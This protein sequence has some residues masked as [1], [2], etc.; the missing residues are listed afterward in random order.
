MCTVSY[1]PT[2][3][4]ALLVSNRD[5]RKH[6]S[7]AHPPA[8]SQ[9]NGQSF[10]FPT[11]GDAG[12][13]WIMAGAHRVGVLLNGAFEAHD[14]QPPYRMSRG[15]VL[16]ELLSAPD[17]VKAWSLYHLQQ[18]EPFTWILYWE[19]QLIEFRWDGQTAHRRDCDPQQAHIWSSA[20]LYD[21]AIRE[22]RARWFAEWLSTQAQPELDA[23]MQFHRFGGEGNL[24]HDFF[25]NR[26][27]EVF[28]VSITGVQVHADHVH[29][30]YKDLIADL[31]YAQQIQF[32]E[33]EAH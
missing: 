2:G 1:L 10:L 7:A 6:R 21:A 22:K 33:V 15:R 20:T 12:G 27:G 29:M 23:L 4:S 9:V 19:G 16:V 13:T 30:V 14:P 25:M 28:T 18:I 3:S 24:H 17:P 11:D 32:T 31:T 5:E 8:P 26:D